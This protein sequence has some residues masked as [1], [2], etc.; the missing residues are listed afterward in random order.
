MKSFF[1]HF[2]L[3]AVIVIQS[4]S[5]NDDS[6]CSARLCATGPAVIEFKIV[7][8]ETGEN[9]A[10]TIISGPAIK[11]INT[12]SGSEATYEFITENDNNILRV[13]IPNSSEYS[14][15]YGEE[16]IFKFSVDAEMQTEDCCSFTKINEIRI[17]DADFE[18]EEET[19]IY[20]IKKSIRPHLTSGESL[21]NYHAFFENSKLQIEAEDESH[22]NTKSLEIDVITGE[23]FVFKLLI[24]EDPEETVADDEIT[25]I[26]YFEI[27]PEGTKFTLNSDN[28]EEAKAVIGL[29]AST[30]YIKPIQ[31]GEITGTKISND[32]WEV[33]VNVS[34]GEED[35]SFSIQVQ[36]SKTDFS[37]STYEDVWMPIYF[38]HVFN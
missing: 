6:D 25:R 31:S 38:T 1:K 8:I 22:V 5:N 9:I 13:S 2:L 24:Y 18:V 3:L 27:D 7:D 14:V 16:E 28:F 35:E 19:D 34:V 32:I 37:K 30:S 10:G 20:I 29:S 15:K 17:D 11:V 33:E 12:S 23:K 26:V 4:C 36:E 21:E